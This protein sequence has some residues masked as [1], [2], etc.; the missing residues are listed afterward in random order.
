MSIWP[1]VWNH[2]DVGDPRKRSQENRQ[3]VLV[4]VESCFGEKWVKILLSD[5]DVVFK[6]LSEGNPE[7]RNT[8]ID[9]FQ[10]QLLFS[11]IRDQPQ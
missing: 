8:Q 7:T 11:N 2:Y 3:G 6:H 10:R 5:Y 9:L 1:H 4:K